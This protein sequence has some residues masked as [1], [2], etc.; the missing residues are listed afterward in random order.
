MTGIFLEN[1]DYRKLHWSSDWNG[2]EVGFPDSLV[3]GY[4]RYHDLN[5][6]IDTETDTVLELWFDEEE[7]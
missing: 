1:L 3:V 5:M 4:Y 2:D 7:E 6:Y